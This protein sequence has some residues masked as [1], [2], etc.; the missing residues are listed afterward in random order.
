[1]DAYWTTFSW[2][3]PGTAAGCLV[4]I[5]V[6]SFALIR[7]NDLYRNKRARWREANIRE[8]EALFALEDH[9]ETPGYQ[10]RGHR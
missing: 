9:R 7:I 8:L 3:N 5:L 6:A 10:S 4:L 1:M 2:H